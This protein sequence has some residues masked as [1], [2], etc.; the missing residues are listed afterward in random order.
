MD[1]RGSELECSLFIMGRIGVLE[2]VNVLKKV[3][4]L[5]LKVCFVCKIYVLCVK[6]MCSG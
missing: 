6:S 4:F 5:V 2:E 3:C 1:C